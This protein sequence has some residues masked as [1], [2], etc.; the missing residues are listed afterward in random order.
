[1]KPGRKPTPTALKVLRGNPGHRPLNQ[2]EPEPDVYSVIP[3]PPEWAGLSEKATELWNDV[4]MVLV[5]MRVFTEA[6]RF[7]LFRYCD[8][9]DSWLK[10]R[11]ECK[12]FGHDNIY[13]EPDPANPGEM[14]IKHTQPHAW[15]SRYVQICKMMQ[16][17]ESELG[18]SPSSRS[19]VKAGPQKDQPVVLR[20]VSMRMGVVTA[21]P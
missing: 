16:S 4:A 19:Q 10:S 12:R 8:L 14:R 11:D 5:K 9:W 18:L 2:D 21:A 20:P 7:L 13:T 6:D 15:S 1:M 3:S 17:I